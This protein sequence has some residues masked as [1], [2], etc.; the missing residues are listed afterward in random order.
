MQ[1]LADKI[2]ARPFPKDDIAC[3]IAAMLKRPSANHS[4]L[5]TPQVE[6]FIFDD[7][8]IDVIYNIFKTEAARK[9]AFAI[10]KPPFLP[11]FVE[12]ANRGYF[13]M[14]LEEDII[15]VSLMVYDHK[16]NYGSCHSRC[17]LENITDNKPFTPEMVTA[18]ISVYAPEAIDDAIHAFAGLPLI[19]AV[20]TQPRMATVEKVVPSAADSPA[21]RAMRRRRAQRGRPMYSFNRVT[22]DLPQHSLQGGEIKQRAALSPRR[23]HNVIGH[24]RLIT[25]SEEPYFVWVQPHQAGDPALGWV[26]KERIIKIK[27]GVRHG[28][29]MPEF[30]GQNGQ[31]VDATPSP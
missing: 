31:R 30:A 25:R 8:A 27:G 24:W 11:M 20:I 18:G 29:L 26:T 17:L 4:E 9:Q 21:L 14:Q 2:A 3:S 19:L 16:N 6:R 22:V 23:G 12:I 15:S 5:H 13:I 1:T 28:Y 10:C 7:A